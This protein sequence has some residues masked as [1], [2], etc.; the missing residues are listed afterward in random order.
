AATAR[1]CRSRRWS[2]T[3]SR[4][5]L[6]TVAKYSSPGFRRGGQWLLFCWEPTR[7]FLTVA[8]SSPDCPNDLPKTFH[9]D[10]RPCLGRGNTPRRDWAIVYGRR[11]AIAGNGRK[12]RYGMAAAIRL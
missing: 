3:P 6:L 2:N 10:L 7:K 5:L 1:R 9:K 11:P 8:P 4:H 12:F